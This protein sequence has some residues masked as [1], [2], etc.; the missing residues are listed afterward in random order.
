MKACNPTRFTISLGGILIQR[1][2]ADGE[3]FTAEPEADGVASVA[4]TDGEVAVSVSYDARWNITLKLL[5]TSDENFKCSQLYNLKRRGYGGVGFFPFLAR[6][7]DTHEFLTGTDAC[8][9]R[10]PTISQDRTAT[11]RE[12]KI[13][14]TNGDYGFFR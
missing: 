7:V 4:G 3:Y 13:L 12:W 5:Q 2:W 8:F 11:T 1:G 9:V 10:A 14:L 6:N